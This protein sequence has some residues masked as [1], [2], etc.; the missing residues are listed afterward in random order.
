MQKGACLQKISAENRQVRRARIA[1][2][3]ACGSVASAAIASSWG[4][5]SCEV[6]SCSTQHRSGCHKCT[7][8]YHDC[9]WMSATG[10]SWL[11]PCMRLCHTSFTQLH[12]RLRWLLVSHAQH[13]CPQL[14]RCIMPSMSAVS[15]QQ[16]PR[17]GLA[18]ASVSPRGSTL[19]HCTP[20]ASA[21]LRLS[22]RKWG[23]CMLPALPCFASARARLGV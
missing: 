18:C 2:G 15:A 5:T 21:Q 16:Q 11:L 12:T 20:S 17:L 9:I 1:A 22:A 10:A 8:T 4:S 23:Q 14:S 13:L 7:C 6:S 3:E 19:S